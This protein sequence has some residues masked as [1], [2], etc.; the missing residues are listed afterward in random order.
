MITAH[1]QWLRLAPFLTGLRVTSLPI[2]TGLVLI[3][4]SVTSPAFVVRWLALH[5]R[6]LDFSRLNRSESESESEL[7]YDVRFTADQFVLATSPVRPKIRILIFQLNTFGCIPYVTSS[8]TRGWV[9]RLQF[10]LGLASAVILRSESCRTHDHISLSEIRDF[11][12]L[13]GQVHVIFTPQKRVARLYPQTLG[14]L[15]VASYDLQGYDGGIRPL[16]H[17]GHSTVLFFSARLLILVAMENVC[18]LVVVTETRLVLNWS[19]GIYLRSNVWYFRV[20]SLHRERAHQAVAQQRTSALAPLF[21][22]SGGMSHYYF[23]RYCTS[24]YE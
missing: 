20:S 4:E 16:L 22:L 9:S 23:S 15:F 10:L 24:F 12:N 21:Q 5:R 19:V 1:N 6:T 11:P 8:L 17:T 18:C 13:E 3:C 2:V 7:L 14:S